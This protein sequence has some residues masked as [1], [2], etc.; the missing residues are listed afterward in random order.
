MA[1]TATAVPPNT[2]MKVPTS[3]AI[4]APT[5]WEA[6]IWLPYRPPPPDSSSISSMARLVPRRT[7]S[8][9]LAS[10]SRPT[11]PREVPALRTL[12]SPSVSS[13]AYPTASTRGSVAG[14]STASLRSPCS[15]L[16]RS[17]F[18]VY[19]FLMP[20]SRPTHRA[21]FLPFAEPFFLG[22]DFFPLPL[23]DLAVFMAFPTAFLVSILTTVFTTTFAIPPTGS[24]LQKVWGGLSFGPTPSCSSAHRH[25]GCHPP[26]YRSERRS[27]GRPM[28]SL[29][30]P[31][32]YPPRAEASAEKSSPKNAPRAPVLTAGSASCG[33]TLG[34]APCALLAALLKAPGPTCPATL[35][36]APKSCPSPSAESSRINTVPSAHT[37][38]PFRRPEPVP[39]MAEV[40]PATAPPVKKAISPM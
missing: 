25:H 4:A 3:S 27:V 20:N 37:M 36:R 17:G 31:P 9:I 40:I 30:L 26:R 13:A 14:R 39:L 16:L 38:K 18:N 33:L 12:G 5:M 2:S 22:P 23:A 29:L 8:S 11:P 34:A 35:P 7:V 10:S 15:L 19:S 6:S 32:R 28:G 24:F 1:P 21:P